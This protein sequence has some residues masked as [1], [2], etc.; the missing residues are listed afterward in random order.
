MPTAPSAIERPP[1]PPRS[2]DRRLVQR[3]PGVYAAIRR[4]APHGRL[5]VVGYPRLF[6]ETGSR[7]CAAG[8]RISSRE[9]DCSNERTRAL[10]AA[11]AGVAHASGAQFVDATDAFDGAELRCIGD[12]FVNRLR[13]QAR[14]CLHP[15]IRTPLAR[16]G[17]Q[18][19]SRVSWAEW[20]T[21][22]RRSPLAFVP[23]R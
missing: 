22:I 3:L 18:R 8:P 20:R 17:S 15:S 4:A 14:L 12:S 6:P 13:L 7:N 16:S 21:W 5:I 10:N 23:S 11:I 2:R 9:A 19:S 1:G